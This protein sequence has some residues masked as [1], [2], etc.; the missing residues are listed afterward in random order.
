[1][2]LTIFEHSAIAAWL[3]ESSARNLTTSLDAPKQN[4]HRNV[5]LDIASIDACDAVHN[6][7][8]GSLDDR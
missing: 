3:V 7:Y 4:P 1:M 6:T 2:E 5:Y 8:H